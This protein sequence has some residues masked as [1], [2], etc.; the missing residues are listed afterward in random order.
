MFVVVDCWYLSVLRAV[1][2][3]CGVLLFVVCRV[4]FGGVRCCLLLLCD[5]CRCVLFAGCC[6]LLLCGVRCLMFVACR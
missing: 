6:S 4:L 1:V 5:A 3:R 2:G